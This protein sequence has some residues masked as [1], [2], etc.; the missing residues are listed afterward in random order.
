MFENEPRTTKL[1]TSAIRGRSKHGRSYTGYVPFAIPPQ[2]DKRLCSGSTANGALKRR[3]GLA[4]RLL[5]LCPYLGVFEFTDSR[6]PSHKLFDL[7]IP[8]IPYYLFTIAVKESVYPAV[9][10]VYNSITIISE[11][12][13]RNSYQPYPIYRL[14]ACSRA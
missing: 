1:A 4:K 6:V 9:I 3:A 7:S 8:T 10:R 14:S 2:E 12:T 11:P 5:W 13:L